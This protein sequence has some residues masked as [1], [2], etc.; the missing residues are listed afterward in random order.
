MC[1]SSKSGHYLRV[2]EG[3]HD[4]VTDAFWRAEAGSREIPRMS[5]QL[6]SWTSC[7]RL[8]GRHVG[9]PT[10]LER[11]I[12]VAEIRKLAMRRAP[13]PIFDYVDGGA[14]DELSL[15]EN[16]E[17]YDKIRFLPKVFRDVSS[18]QTSTTLLGAPSALPIALGPTGF[19]RMVHCTGELGVAWA[20]NRARVPYT[21]AT[22]GTTSPADIAH[23]TPDTARWFQLYPHKDHAATER[24]IA[25]AESH[26]YGVLMVT[27]D[28]S[29][30]GSKRRDQ[31]HGLTIPPTI[32][33]RTLAEMA[34]R[35]AWCWDILTT[36][37]LGFDTLQPD[38][39][40]SFTA[41]LDG[42][43]MQGITVEFMQWL[44]RRWSKTLVVKGI[45]NVADAELAFALDV[46][47]IV[48][49]NHGGRQLDRA[50][51]PITLVSEVRRAV[52]PDRE[53]LIDSGIRSGVDVAAA[54]AS[55]ANG[56]LIGRA[57]LYGLMAAGP[58]GVARVID[59]IDGELRR[60]MSLLGARTIAELTPDLLANGPRSRPGEQAH[61]SA[62]QSGFPL[63]AV[64][65]TFTEQRSS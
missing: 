53:I 27:L 30:I 29:V 9:R 52:G 14:E 62:D 42:L 43:F 6:P 32:T 60:T 24:L 44:R 31:R 40:A 25:A 22:L 13:R 21:L 19:T 37:P 17:A 26:G 1:R 7:R 59:I 48:L 56:C 50:T 33:A 41:A 10:R 51:A 65:N 39:G 16:R 57:Y 3:R 11:A 49:S 18:L 28:T 20:A 34:L 2:M 38:D 47:A 4:L 46:D 36:A 64:N 55:G 61:S 12:T 5:R 45:S 58:R 35:P 54:I 15:R 63:S 23:M 8:L